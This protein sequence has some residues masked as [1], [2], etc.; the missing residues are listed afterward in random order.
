MKYSVKEQLLKLPETVVLWADENNT[1]HE[2]WDKPAN[3]RPIAVKAGVKGYW[4]VSPRV[5]PDHF[6][7]HAGEGGVPATKAQ[8]AAMLHGS[9]F[10]FGI[11]ISD[12]DSYNEDGVLH[13]S[14]NK[15]P[16][17]QEA[18]AEIV[19]LVGGDPKYVPANDM[20][21]G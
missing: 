20:K 10:G 21:K 3:A 13:A 11:P 2:P 12:P 6:N 19:A 17:I 7:S 9:V 15:K 16:T 1:P 18:A 8:I 5:N 14:P 4:A